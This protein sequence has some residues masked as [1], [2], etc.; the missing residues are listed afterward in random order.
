MLSTQLNMLFGSLNVVRVKKPSEAPFSVIITRDHFSYSKPDFVDTT[1]PTTISYSQF[2]NVEIENNRNHK[3]VAKKIFA[4]GIAVTLNANQ[5]YTADANNLIQRELSQQL[6]TVIYYW[7]IASN[8]QAKL[9]YANI[10]KTA[11]SSS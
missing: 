2:A 3:T 4:T 10:D 5:I 7:F 1:L 6:V 8:T 9:H 11:R